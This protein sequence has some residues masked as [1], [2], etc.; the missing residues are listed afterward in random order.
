MA[1]SRARIAV[2]SVA[3]ISLT[4]VWLFVGEREGALPMLGSFVDTFSS[5]NL[6]AT[7]T[8]STSSSPAKESPAWGIEELWEGNTS[9]QKS[10]AAQSAVLAKNLQKMHQAPRE[11]L[12]TERPDPKQISVVYLLLGLATGERPV[13]ASDADI[14]MPFNPPKTCPTCPASA[15]KFDSSHE[16]SNAPKAWW[17]AQRYYMEALERLTIQHP[18]ANWYFLADADTVV[19]PHVLQSMMRLLDLVLVDTEDLY[20]GHGRDLA[21][22]RFIMSGGGVLLRG[23]TL[24]RLAGSR[25]LRDCGRRHLNGTWCWRHL[26]WVIA[27]CLREVDIHPRGHPAFQQFATKCS[28]CCRSDSVACHPYKVKADQ[29]KVVEKHS[30]ADTSQLTADWAMPCNGEEYRWMQSKQSI[31]SSRK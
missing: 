2:F 18:S 31:C 17:C 6:T 25:K 19:F 8:N 26:D 5:A 3:A 7:M 24:R 14:F 29:E 16:Y 22:G 1:L 20:M 9:R 4:L 10:L 11:W 27:D 30:S 13:W 28:G 21:I 23:R 15:L 12:Q